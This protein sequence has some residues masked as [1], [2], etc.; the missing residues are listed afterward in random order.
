MSIS[1]PNKTVR[2]PI[3]SCTGT[4]T[5]T[6]SFDAAP[7][8]STN[9]ADIVLIMDRSGSMGGAPLAAAKSAAKQLVD[10]VAK[11]SGSADG[12]AILNG[13]RLGIV[14]FADTATA[15]LGLTGDVAALGTAIDALTAG[16]ST[17]H[18]A[19]FES[20]EAMLLPSASPRRIVIMFTDGVT[21]TGGDPVPVTQ[22]IK[23]SGM[24][25]Y[26]IGL[27][28]TP[29]PL[30]LWASAPA[31][32]YVALAADTTQLDEAFSKV[33][34]EVVL[35]GALDMK[36][37]EVLNPDFKI[38]GIDPPS[39]GTAVLI[40]PQK[41]EWTAPAVGAAGAETATLS[42]EILHIGTD[43]GVKAVNDSITYSDRQGNSLTFPDPQVEVICTSIEIIEP[44][45]EPENFT[46]LG[47]QDTVI[48]ASQD[49]LLSGLGRIVQ[50][51]TLVKNV[52]PNK[53]VAVAVVLSELDA[54]SVEH[55]RGLK[56]VLIP[57]QGGTS[58]QDIQLKCITFVLPEALDEIGRPDSICN[59][60]RF[61][62][63]VFANY[64]DTDFV[65]CDAQTTV[66]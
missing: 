31:S 56:T 53:R 30:I 63:R 39:H 54:Q 41:L 23:A 16:G 38:V 26:C 46:I 1:N 6:L 47:C 33:A 28:T 62:V 5:V 40:D 12:S 36:I 15:D 50:I 10:T 57:A 60:R 20:G 37:E 44:C 14:S 17:N 3:M 48:T 58:C 11:A 25:I 35:A 51:D 7:E 52:C 2:S 24:E 4:N 22:S 18:K 59:P 27:T 42:F 8:L 21:T 43:G 66:F 13:S 45:P 64:I 34:G 29:A 19:A 9:P 55:P 65:C 61:S 32:T 49:A